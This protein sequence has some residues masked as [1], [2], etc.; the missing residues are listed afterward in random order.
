MMAV[1]PLI[2]INKMKIRNILIVSN[3]VVPLCLTATTVMAQVGEIQIEAA[4][5]IMGIT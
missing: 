2:R 4:S 5:T 1:R 3:V